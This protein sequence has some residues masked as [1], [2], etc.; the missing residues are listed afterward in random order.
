MGGAGYG[1][2]Q[3]LVFS[4]YRVGD[5][6]AATGGVSGT[7]DRAG[8]AAAPIAG[9]RRTGNRTSGIVVNVDKDR[10]LPLATADVDANAVQVAD[11]HRAAG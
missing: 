10:P 11:V 9:Y 4:T 1:E 3:R 7:F 2:G 5:S 6:L 8:E